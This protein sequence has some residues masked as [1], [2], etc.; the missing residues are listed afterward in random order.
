MSS[1]PPWAVW[2]VMC[3]IKWLGMQLSWWRVCLVG[4]KRLNPS[5]A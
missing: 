4:T 5:T 1:R 2:K 3:Q